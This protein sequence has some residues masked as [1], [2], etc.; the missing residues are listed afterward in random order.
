MTGWFIVYILM[1]VIL[2]G[3]AILILASKRISGWKKAKWVAFA[4]LPI[5]LVPI[6]VGV[7]VA[8]YL[9]PNNQLAGVYTSSIIPIPTYLSVWIMFVAFRIKNPI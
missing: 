8:L 6:L 9:G 5:L 7:G 2:F 1:A 4:L 3:P